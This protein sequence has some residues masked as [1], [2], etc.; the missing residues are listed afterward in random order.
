M[1]YQEFYIPKADWNVKVYYSI[2]CYNIY[3]I[4]Q[5]LRDIGCSGSNLDEAYR[6][7]FNNDLNTG[8]TYS[9]PSSRSSVIVIAH[10]S[11]TKQFA[12]SLAHEQNHLKQHIAENIGINPYSE[13]DCYLIGEIAEKM[14]K[15][16]KKLLCECCKKKI[17]K[18]LY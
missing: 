4:L 14:F 7:L 10:S 1:I 13:D 6:L 8:L 11:S 16:A 15:V 5:S 2:T 9:N 3:D 18:R 12:N 17:Y